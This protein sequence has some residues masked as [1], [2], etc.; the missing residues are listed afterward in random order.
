[1][2]SAVSGCS[3]DEQYPA[4]VS[5]DQLSGGAFVHVRRSKKGIERWCAQGTWCGMLSM[6]IADIICG[7]Y[8]DF[9]V[10]GTGMA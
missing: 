3:R 2:C 4:H 5:R 8:Q 1:M 6:D 9:S 10:W 7:I